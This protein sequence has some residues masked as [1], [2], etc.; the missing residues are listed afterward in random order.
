MRI[1]L[2]A[3]FLL[4]GLSNLQGQNVELDKALGAE[5]AE[6][7]KAQMGIYDDEAKT[8]YIRKV[9][10]RLVSELDKQLFDYEIHL[11]PD[12][13]PNAFA[14][15]GGHLFI[16]TGLI[17]ILESEDELACIIGHEIIH[18]NNR[19]TIKQMK[20]SIL[21]KLLEVP[22]NLIGVMNKDLGDF[23]TAPVETSN[24][25]L[26]ASYGRSFETEAD[27]QGTQLAASAGYDPEAM[28]SVLNRMSKSI[29]AA[30]GNAEEKSYFNDH[31]YTPD[32]AKSIEKT[33]SKIDTK[34]AKPISAYF[35]KEMD[36]IIFGTSPEAGII[37]DNSF[38]HPSLNFRI[39]FPSNWQI[40]NESSKVA[41]YSP[42]K[43][44]AAFIGIEG[45]FTDPKEA[46]THFI[47]NMESE[48]KS[49]MINAEPYL[50]NNTQ[51]YLISFADKVQ[52]I[53]M[54]AYILWVPLDGKLFKLIG[55][56][57]NTHKSDLEATAA[58]LR[59]LNKK[60]KESFT[61]NFMRTIKAKDN[62][63][64]E[65]LSKR[66]GNLLNLELT[67]IIN[68]KSENE[69]LKNGELV[70]IVRAYPYSVKE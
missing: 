21:P 50:N 55:I 44:G 45:Y 52:G 39:R 29:E 17:P 66:T 43:Q 47:Q 34:K 63:S 8:R 36:S 24:K 62:E 60:E 28:I 70:K 41:G 26:F 30:T 19:H 58:S 13:T 56:G 57:P 22:G 15:P 14:L 42:D 31:P 51:G 27:D 40:E 59:A 11:V 18:S 1:T 16:T 32:R 53:D 23:L 4:V 37:R 3:L 54:Y 64:V 7:V 49:K 20:K 65:Q 2:N 46:G 38:L 48:Y 6:M 61:I 12:M 67:R 5:N 68:S 35:L 9:T 33:I 69:K 25:L 10:A